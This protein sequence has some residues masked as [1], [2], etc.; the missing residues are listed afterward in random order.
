MR[1]R[2]LACS[3][4]LCG[5]GQSVPCTWRGKLLSCEATQRVSIYVYG[6]HATEV[7]SPKKKKLTTAQK[8]YCREKA[9]DHIRPLRI[10]HG[11]SRK[12]STPLEDLPALSVV[13]N[14][15]NHYSRTY[16]DNHD[17]TFTFCWEA[18]AQGLPKVGDGSDERPFIVGMPTKGLIMQLLMPPDAFILHVDATYKMNHRGYPVIV[19]GVSD[20][21]RVFHLVALFVV[22][23]ETQEVFEAVLLSLQRVFYFITRKNLVVR[24]AMADD[25]QAQY[26][27]L[28]TVFDQTQGFT[29]LMC[30]FFMSSR[31]YT[32]RLRAFPRLYRLA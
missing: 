16:L 29:F 25:D 22:S 10:R 12:F 8:T 5:E 14:F 30:F 3:S 1:C 24:Y 6:A 13:Q 7:S 28:N 11:M 2:L 19:V 31:T 15:V 17:R 20:R 18:D 27:A 4:S 21:A 23:Q 26:N 32:R 9:D